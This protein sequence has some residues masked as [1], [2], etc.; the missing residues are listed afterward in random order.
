RRCSVSSSRV[1]PRSGF[2]GHSGNWGTS[3]GGRAPPT[4]FHLIH[5]SRVSSTPATTPPFRTSDRA[6]GH[7]TKPRPHFAPHQHHPPRLP[8]LDLDLQ[9]VSRFVAKRPSNRDS[10]TEQC[11]KSAD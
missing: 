7:P 3:G 8:Q 6:A 11:N 2:P 1:S 9:L 4:P 10:F 5:A